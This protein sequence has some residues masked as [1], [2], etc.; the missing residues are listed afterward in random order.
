M[1]VP[2]DRAVVLADRIP[3]LVVPENRADLALSVGR[4]AQPGVLAIQVLLD[5]AWHR[6]L[7]R[8]HARST[9]LGIDASGFLGIGII[10]CAGRA[11]EAFGCGRIDHLL[12]QFRGRVDVARN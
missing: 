8:I 12:A 10:A 2:G 3:L 7:P 1:H 5:H 4:I 11:G 9:G 6:I